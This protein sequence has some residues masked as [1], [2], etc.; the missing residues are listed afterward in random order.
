MGTIASLAESLVSLFEETGRFFTYLGR[1]IV[2]LI[3]PPWDIREIGRQMVRVG[4]QSI[5]VVIFTAAFTGAVIALQ[6]YAGFAR[7]KA[8]GFVG[9]VVALSMLR[10][11]SP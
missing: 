3:I 6:T 4:V 9:G 1:V 11:V 8:E 5:P 7:F 2:G 10:E